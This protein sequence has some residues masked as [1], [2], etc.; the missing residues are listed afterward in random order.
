MSTKRFLVAL[1]ALAVVVSLLP[2]AVVGAGTEDSAERGAITFTRDVQPIL[3]EKCQSCHRPAGANLSGMIAPMS[4]MSY[5]EVRP[6]ARSIA[7]AVENREMPPW[8][9]SQEFHGVFA[10]E[11][12]LTDQEIDTV[13]RWAKTGA[14]RGNAE[15]A[16]E[17]RVFPNTDGWSIG[18]PDLI[19]TF[20]EPFFVEDDVED[21]YQN[22]TVQLSEEQLPQDRWIKGLQFRPGS[23]VVHHIIGYAYAS[24]AG[25]RPDRGMLG[26]IAPG[27]D[28]STFPEGYGLLLRKGSTVVFQ[29][30]Y[31]KEPGPGT[32]A[33]DRSEL[34]FVFHDQ[35][36]NHPVRI[37]AIAHRLFEIPPQHPN[38]RV[39]SAKIFEQDTTILGLLPHMHL[40][41]KAARY[42]AF[43]PDG[44]R[45]VLLDVPRY[46]FN[47]QT[48]YE[49]REPKK[50]P[51]GTRVEVNLWFDNS[52]ERAELANVNPERAV[53]FGGPTTDEMDLG[54]ITY[55]DTEPVGSPEG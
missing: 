2:G 10:N 5:Q 28:P 44:S 26:G 31:H 18:K 43:Y 55:G 41:G 22:I 11:R 4:L 25:S 17:P 6:W 38:W 33:W 54:W 35:P 14:P 21:L 19:V 20:D 42:T 29:M 12:T 7:R 37:E 53:R 1:A 27:S 39:G 46:D 16:P 47:W 24:G 52:E 30:H 51:A 23:P 3:Q 40:R 15:D 49:F 32:G 8:H 13:V 9:A 45:E 50:I 48:G 34:A 36:V